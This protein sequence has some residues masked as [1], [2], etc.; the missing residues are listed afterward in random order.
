MYGTKLTINRKS[1]AD[2]RDSRGLINLCTMRAIL[3]GRNMEAA[4]FRK[5]LWQIICLH[6]GFFLCRIRKVLNFWSM[7]PNVI[8][9]S[10][11]YKKVTT[12]LCRFASK[13][14]HTSTNTK[15]YFLLLHTM[16]HNWIG[17]NFIWN[18]IDIHS[19]H[20]PWWMAT[21]CQDSRQQNEKS[22][23]KLSVCKL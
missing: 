15:T 21:V 9:M 5:E 18:S 7:R 6:Y 12:N 17:I 23:K 1:E 20:M 13:Y 19:S 14:T 16:Q 11:L 3:S 2:C 8:E 4:V 22:S 10:K